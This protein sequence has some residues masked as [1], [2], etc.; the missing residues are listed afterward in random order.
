MV[1]E[2]ILA[3]SAKAA[4]LNKESLKIDHGQDSSRII[5]S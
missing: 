2:Q 5:V 3:V 1:H 4:N